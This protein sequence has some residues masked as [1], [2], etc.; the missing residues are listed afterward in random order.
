MFLNHNFMNVVIITTQDLGKSFRLL[1][2]AKSFAAQPDTHVYLIGSDKNSLPK[3]I[4]NSP[5][6]THKYMA[7]F[8]NVSPTISP[9]L[10][11]IRFLFYLVSYLLYSYLLPKI[12]IIVSSTA[13]LPYDPIFA[14]FLKRIKKCQLVFD[15]S[16]YVYSRTSTQI[17]L[18]RRFEGR[19]PRMADI[20]IAPTR[21]IQVVLQTQ[22]IN[23][24]LIRDPPGTLFKP[25]PELR[26]NVN[27]YLSISS[28]SWLIGVAFPL[29]NERQLQLISSIATSLDRYDEKIVFAVFCNGKSQNSLEKKFEGNKCRNIE[30]KFIP[31]NTD[32][33]CHILSTCDFGIV[34]SGSQYGLDISPELNEM[35]SCNI[36]S[37]TFQFGCVRE[38]LKDNITGFVLKDEEQLY[39]LLKKIC[40]DKEINIDMMKHNC[41]ELN[42]NWEPAWNEF[43]RSLAKKRD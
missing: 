41:S 3:D 20:K 11:P 2:H 5:N 34:F 38:L 43:Y 32:A 23:S 30:F 24:F 14:A 33:Y 36:P 15:I 7:Q 13:P 42:L 25:A 9:L 12:D 22:K 10:F 17:S 1:N 8:P 4:E 35:L 27:E 16:P 6:I 31:M 19:I 39:P 26:N 18:L 21:A 29:H 28:N 40:V 37:I